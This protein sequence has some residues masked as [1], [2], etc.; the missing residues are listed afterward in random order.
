MDALFH[1]LN[2]RSDC[3]N[4][5]LYESQSESIRITSMEASDTTNVQVATFADE[6]AGWAVDPGSERDATMDLADNTVSDSLGNFLERPVALPPFVWGVNAPFLQKFNPWELFCTDPYVKAKI[7]S[8]ELLRCNLCVKFTINGTPFHYGRLMASYNPLSGFDQVTVQRNFFDQDLI[9]ASQKPHVFLNPTKSEGGTLCLPFFFRDN[10]MSLSDKDYEDMGEIIIKSFGTLQHANQ[11]NNPV[12]VRAF[13]WAEDVV[14]TMP[15]TL[16]S[17]SGKA[18]KLGPDE[19]GQG[20]ISKPASAIAK[21][22][23][24]LKDSPI[25]GP[26]ARATEM[27]AS[28]VGDVAK[29]FG[30]SR[31][32]LLQNEMVVKPQ[33]GGNTANSDAPENIH[34]LTLDSKAEVT[35]DPRVTG[36]TS[37]DEMNILSLLKR[38]SYL[39][40]FNFSTDS[41]INDMLWQ[42]RVNPSLHG[43]LGEEIHPTS[44]AFI[45][46]YFKSWQGSIKFRFQVVRSN[47]HQG[48]IVVRYDPNSF[49]SAAVNY[50]VNYSRIVDISEEEDFEVIVGW[51]QKSPFLSVPEMDFGNN[52]FNSGP[53]RLSTDSSK[54]HNGVLEVDVVNELVCPASIST[55]QIN[56]YVSMCDDAKFAD[57]V[58]DRLNH[59]HLFIEPL[60]DI[61]GIL[62]S[63]SGMENTDSTDKPGESVITTTLTK[64]MPESDQMMNV[65]YGET[66][67]SLRELCK[68]YT[69]VRS[70]ILPHSDVRSLYSYSALLNK[71]LPYQT[72]YDPGGLDNSDL[73]GGEK[74]TLGF[75]S[76]IAYFMPAFAGYRGAMRHK[77]VCIT[78][79]GLATFNGFV[80]RR[81][82]LGTGNGSTFRQDMLKANS[83]EMALAL[84]SNTAAGT[85][86]QYLTGNSVMQVELPFYNQGRIGYSRL[87]SAQNLNCNSHEVGVAGTYQGTQNGVM[88]NDFVAAGEDFS[89]YFFTGA[90]ILF[91]YTLTPTS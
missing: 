86:V 85:S 33:F 7:S 39:T 89:L 69:L 56:V 22:A 10:Y 67:T 74:L 35:I 71:D 45:M 14:L 55:I 70:W 34:K 30:F 41:S 49:G 21:A 5:I 28:G 9:G 91:K 83:K 37:Q 27:V 90:P 29:L 82:F 81:H 47:Y 11:G 60:P 87:I 65:F 52:W 59:Y 1:H 61:P 76:P 24:L 23:G 42:C 51:G 38:E 73:Y 26:Y 3:G 88:L 18:R 50:N 31:P 79:L 68:R 46:N 2:E 40:T 84:T 64:T 62:N 78:D 17:Q 80:T 4:S 15:T 6:D 57:P 16:T 54:Q 13:V 8:F 53:A 20:I 32:P 75:K 43:A 66:P 48:R 72:G 63:Q 77:Y 58:S 25:I 19:Y 12:T 44:M 36:L